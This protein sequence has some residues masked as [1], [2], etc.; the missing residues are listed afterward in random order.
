MHDAWW[1]RLELVGTVRHVL[2]S[3][4]SHL[5]SLLIDN[6]E[7]VHFLCPRKSW[8]LR[9]EWASSL[10]FSQWCAEQRWLEYPVASMKIHRYIIDLQLHTIAGTLI[11]QS[12]VFE[13]LRDKMSIIS[14][15]REVRKAWTRK[16]TDIRWEVRK[17][18]HRLN[19]ASGRW[20]RHLQI[21]VR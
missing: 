12:C 15:E 1:P 16:K 20:R 14:Y 17:T 2:C 9:N 11:I 8:Y 18:S 3:H 4:C 13:Y 6:R 5:R 21:L 10:S 19:L 7:R